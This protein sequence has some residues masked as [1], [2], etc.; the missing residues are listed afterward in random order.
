MLRRTSQQGRPRA[1]EASA[2]DLLVAGALYFGCVL[3]VALSLFFGEHPRCRRTPLSACHWAITQGL[4][5]AVE[6][7]V[8]RACG[9]RGRHRLAAAEAACCAGSNPAVQILFLFLLGAGY[10]G[11]NASVFPMLPAAGLPAWHFYTGSA[12]AL[13]CLALF[14]AACLSDPGIVACSNLE[15]HLALYPHDGLLFQP[16]S[17][18]TCGFIKPARSKH[19][20]ILNRC[21]ARYDHYCIWLNGP[22]GLLNTR[23]FLAL[24]AWVCLL[25]TYGAVLASRAV[26]GDMART[27]AWRVAF[28]HP[29]TGRLAFVGDSW[30]NTAQYVVRTYGMQASW[31]GGGVV[32]TGARAALVLFL[33]VMGW[34]VLGFLVYH[35][36]LIASGATTN[37][38]FKWREVR[39]CLGE[40][41]DALREQSEADALMERVDQILAGGGNS[42]NGN[43]SD[44][45][46]AGS[47]GGA[48]AQQQQERRGGAGSRPP[49]PNPYHRG[50][51]ANLSETER[52]SLLNPRP[53]PPRPQTSLMADSLSDYETYPLEAWLQT[54]EFGGRPSLDE[55]EG[56]PATQ[57][58][59]ELDA[60]ATEEHCSL[61]EGS[62]YE[63]LSSGPVPTS[64]ML[65]QF[66]PFFSSPL[67][68]SAASHQ[69]D[70]QGGGP[71]ADEERAQG[72]A[73]D[74]RDSELYGE[75]PRRCRSE[76]VQARLGR[77]AALVDGRLQAI[78][79]PADARLSG[80]LAAALY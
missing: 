14:A 40:V 55:L 16:L 3:T 36:W 70:Q 50:A 19:C 43:G 25:C 56:C 9:E 80:T 69:T 23:W 51:W 64:L 1:S 72:G 29:T 21:V 20:R 24:L 30:R 60:V 62:D 41:C 54:A 28:V 33:G 15:E 22:V 57:D 17:C 63:R 58:Q 78:Q 48:A 35:L 5:L 7:L 8:V 18:G 45:P 31:A 65:N 12:A 42:N 26:L 71:L 67:S 27:D 34:V 75:R 61:H 39:A 4:C 73:W 77:V 49:P 44:G 52:V 74:W 53:K 32:R 2:M 59:D 10:W 38:S 37:E 76:E 6:R 68:T 66:E 13:A 11:F 47:G 46:R 79:A